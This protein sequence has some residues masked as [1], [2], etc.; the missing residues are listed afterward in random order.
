MVNNLTN[1]NITNKMYVKITVLFVVHEEEKH[2]LMNT[3][4]FRLS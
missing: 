1:I 3:A 2:V 4:M